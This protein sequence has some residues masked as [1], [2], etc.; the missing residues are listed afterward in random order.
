MIKSFM[1]FAIVSSE[2]IKICNVKKY[3]TKYVINKYITLMIYNIICLIKYSI[4]N[5]LASF[6]LANKMM[7]FI[8]KI[9]EL[10]VKRNNLGS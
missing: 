9:K 2:N 8:L 5:S 7:V 4:I 3:E 6:F 1:V 10:A